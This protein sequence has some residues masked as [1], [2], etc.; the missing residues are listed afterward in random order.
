[1]PK[2]IEV[3]TDEF[4]ATLLDARRYRAL[5]WQAA[6]DGVADFPAFD[7]KADALLADIEKAKEALRIARAEGSVGESSP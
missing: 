4:T 3:L 7:A 5:K 1:M 2:Y 6:S